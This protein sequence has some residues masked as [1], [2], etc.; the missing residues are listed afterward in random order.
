MFAKPPTARLRPP[1]GP[2]QPGL[3]RGSRAIREARTFFGFF[4]AAAA[5]AVAVAVAAAAVVFRFFACSPFALRRS[6]A[7]GTKSS[8]ESG[9]WGG[10]F[11]A[12]GGLLWS[13][14]GLLWSCP[15]E[16][17]SQVSVGRRQQS[18][19]SREESW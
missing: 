14:V 12:G 11:S 9:D 19:P 5:V 7:S 2:G 6:S 1:L 18:W 13:C 17:A 3:S 8:V 16:T 10:G 4:G 15:C